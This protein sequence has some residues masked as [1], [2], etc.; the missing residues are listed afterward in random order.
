MLGV[1]RPTSGT[2]TVRKTV[3]GVQIEGDPPS[4]HD[5]P[6]KFIEREL[7][8]AIRVQIIIP[9]EEEVR[10]EVVRVSATEWTANRI[11][12]SKPPRRRWWQRRKK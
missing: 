2:L 11:K 8:D 10:Y 7:G 3:R 1:S 12:Q 6:L 4:R 5:F 9:A